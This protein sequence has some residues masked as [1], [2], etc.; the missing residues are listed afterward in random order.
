M[1]VTGVLNPALN[2]Q[3]DIALLLG[4]AERP[5]IVVDFS[6]SAGKTVVL[7]GDAPG[8]FPGGDP[9]NDYF[10]GLANTNTVNAKTLATNGPNSR[11]HMKFVVGTTI[12]GAPDLPNSIKPGFD[13]TTVAAPVP[14]NSEPLLTTVSPLGVVTPSVP[15][16]RTIAVGLFEGF[17]LYG[18]LEQFVGPVLSG[19]IPYDISGLAPEELHYQGDVEI[20][21]VYNTT[22]DVHPMHFHLYNA[23][24]INRQ[25]F[26][27]P[28][29]GG[30][31]GTV[32]NPLADEYGFKET[33]KCWPG[34]I[35]RFIVRVGVPPILDFQGNIIPCPTSPRGNPL[36]QPFDVYN[37]NE[38]VWH[39]HI[40]EHEEHDMMRP[41]CV[42]P[43]PGINAPPVSPPV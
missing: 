12:S 8:P 32:R 35:L 21:E 15:V 24:V 10:P 26:L 2:T 3:A 25:A 27:V 42:S 4:P 43:I 6:L 37:T 29:D 17:D 5:D 33:I 22:A 30:T 41:L 19:G 39:C 7:Y 16:T 18:R 23:Q 11:I 20:W 34:E 28:G 14:W 13:L 9:R 40:L 38:Y 36:G 1:T 31:A